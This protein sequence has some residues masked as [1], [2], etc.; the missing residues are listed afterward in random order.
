[1]KGARICQ[2]RCSHGFPLRTGPDTIDRSIGS[3][4]DRSSFRHDLLPPNT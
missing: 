2:S 3:G 1:M 4:C